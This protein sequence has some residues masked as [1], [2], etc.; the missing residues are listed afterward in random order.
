MSLIVPLDLDN[1]I[2]NIFIIMLYSIV[3]AAVYFIFIIKTKTLD[4][5]FGEKIDKFL[6]KL[7]K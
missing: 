7:V 1:R 3:G 2:L 4:K 5:I 6:K